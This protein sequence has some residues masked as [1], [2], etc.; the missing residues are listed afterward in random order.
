M[1]EYKTLEDIRKYGEEN[2]WSERTINN[3]ICRTKETIGEKIDTIYFHMICAEFDYNLRVLRYQSRMI[4]RMR[5]ER[6]KRKEEKENTN[7]K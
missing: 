6:E 5:G 1:K 2:G 4:K 7:K 3:C